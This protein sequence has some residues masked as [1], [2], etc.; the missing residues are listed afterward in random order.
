MKTMIA[1]LVIVLLGMNLALHI[2]KTEATSIH[3]HE[4]VIEDSNGQ[5]IQSD[6]FQTGSDLSG[7][8]MPIAPQR[9]GYVFVGWSYDLSGTM[10]DADIII[11]PQ[12]IE[13]EVALN[14]SLS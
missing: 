12:Y 6:L 4:I 9:E 11:S 1:A 3:I 2:S 5:V 13:A 7:Y 14:Y 10:P 8:E